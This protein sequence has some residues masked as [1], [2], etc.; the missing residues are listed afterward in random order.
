MSII[1]RLISY[2][3][4]FTTYSIGLLQ[5]KSYRVLK[6]KTTHFLLPYKLS[7]IDWALLGILYET[8]EDMYL[9]EIADVLGVKAPFVT[10]LIKVLEKRGL[11]II[12]RSALDTRAKHMYLTSSGKQ[13]VKT[14]ESKLRVVSKSWLTDASPR[15]LI[16]YVRV[17]EAIVKSE[18]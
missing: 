12:E 10:R 13:L 5:A 6:H 17:L 11:I 15:D 3:K 18:E 2:K 14:I 8:T 4:K 9:S 1:T 16:G 7:T